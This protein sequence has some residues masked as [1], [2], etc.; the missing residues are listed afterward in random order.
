M[1]H[2]K[3]CE[4]ENAAQFEADEREHSTQIFQTENINFIFVYYYIFL[5]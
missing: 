4:F 1:Q 5:L 2:S 3:T